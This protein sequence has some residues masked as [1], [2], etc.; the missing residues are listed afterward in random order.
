MCTACVYDGRRRGGVG[1]ARR[2]Q[3]AYEIEKGGSYKSKLRLP[4]SPLYYPVSS[5]C[6]PLFIVRVLPQISSTSTVRTLI[7]MSPRTLL[8]KYMGRRG[9]E[10]GCD[11]R[12]A[13]LSSIFFEFISVLL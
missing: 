6:H 11:G 10:K 9:V 7:S 2:T 8:Y 5:L 12:V 13:E 4:L 1:V 3:Y